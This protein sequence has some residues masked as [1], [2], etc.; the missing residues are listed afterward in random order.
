MN[1]RQ[2]I[3]GAAVVRSGVI[4][5]TCTMLLGLAKAHEHDEGGRS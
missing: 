5:D 3:V 1:D 4:R 2:A